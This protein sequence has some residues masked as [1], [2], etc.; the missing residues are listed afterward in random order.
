MGTVSVGLLILPILFSTFFYL[1]I[2]ERLS[3]RFKIDRS[4]YLISLSF[5]ADRVYLDP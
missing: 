4:S 1:Q 2:M 5:V 3:S